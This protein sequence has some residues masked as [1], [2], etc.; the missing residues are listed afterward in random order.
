M[1]KRLQKLF[2][3]VVPSDVQVKLKVTESKTPEDA[4]ALIQILARHALF[5]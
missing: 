5:L 4:A 2:C 3:A 1:N